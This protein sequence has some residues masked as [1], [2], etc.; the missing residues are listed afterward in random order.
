MAKPGYEKQAPWVPQCV[1]PS[2]CGG[3][4]GVAPSSSMLMFAIG[5][6]QSHVTFKICNNKIIK[7]IYA[8]RGPGL[9]EPIDISKNTPFLTL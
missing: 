4:V 9:M 6:Q 5:Y 2:R 3:S 7:I 1:A 8:F